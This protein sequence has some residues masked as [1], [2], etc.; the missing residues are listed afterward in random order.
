[1]T[2]MATGWVGCGD[3]AVSCILL[4][5]ARTMGYGRIAGDVRS[6]TNVVG[7]LVNL[8][9]GSG[10]NGHGGDGSKVGRG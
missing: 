10:S 9:F 5:E 7:R 4:M 6:W 2:S 8:Y 3:G 1:M